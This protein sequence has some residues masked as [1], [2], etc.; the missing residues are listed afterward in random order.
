M[1]DR[2]RRI[3]LVLGLGAAAVAV[4]VAGVLVILVFYDVNDGGNPED[5]RITVE[6]VINR[7]ETDRRKDP[8]LGGEQ[9]QV[10][11]IIRTA[12]RLK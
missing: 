12:V 3:I 2:L 4:I 1:S 11:P 6:E 7:V 8:V 9:F 5:A 10:D